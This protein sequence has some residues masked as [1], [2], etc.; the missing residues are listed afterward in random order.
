MAGVGRRRFCAGWGAAALALGC[1]A[2]RSGE[3]SATGL[4]IRGAQVYTEGGLREVDL[5]TAGSVVA[6][7][8]RG[9]APRRGE[10]VLEGE[11]LLALP[12]GIDPH[13]H[14]SPSADP[15]EEQEDF[16]DN[17]THGSTAALAGGVT[18]VGVMVFP[19]G[20]VG[21]GILPSIERH[22]R[23]A[24]AQS[25]VDVMLHPVSFSADSA[26]LAAIEP[27]AR[28]GH[29][30]LKIFAVTRDYE[31]DESAFKELI[32]RAGSQRMLTLLHCERHSVNRAEIDR[33]MSSGKGDLRHYA[34]SSPVR[35]EVEAIRG[36]IEIAEGTGS[37]IYV[38]HLSSAAGL[39]ECTKA[40]ERGV[41]IYVETRPM[42][43]Y[44]TRAVYER[45]DGPLFIGQPPL[46]E[47][48]D[49]AALWEGIER[50]DID[51]IGSDHAPFTAAVKLDP[52]ATVDKYSAGTP[53]LQMMLPMLYSEGVATGRISLDRFVALTS[54]RAARLF[55]LYPRKGVLRAGSDADISL[56]DP[57]LRRRVERSMIRSRA[58]YDIN[59]GR[60]VQGWPVT[61][62][63]RGEVVL[64]DDKVVAE[65]GSGLVLARGPHE[66]LVLA[67][68]DP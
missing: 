5:R 9:L 21:A 64:R 49:V 48:A 24:A 18:T 14:L 59:E 22:A 41:P 33:L 58:G 30:S 37:P 35:S 39:A 4:L 52:T 31:R 34:E 20:S 26:A 27:L 19:V 51:T 50:G 53:G 63:R 45:E 29:T 23:S 36:G 15:P 67:R 57:N 11:G 62:I 60:E 65:P 68:D 38:V 55:G 54:T 46:R 10:R 56:W 7:L 6:E 66:P 13:V 44:H 17:Y 16:C 25:M 2:W 32:R 3:S 61:V 28:M 1:P 8:G 47:E 40:R 42:Y 12:G 43:L